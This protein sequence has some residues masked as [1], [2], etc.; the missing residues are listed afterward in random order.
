[1]SVEGT[2][3]HRTASTTYCYFITESCASNSQKCLKFVLVLPLYLLLQI[4]IPLMVEI[5]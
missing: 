1:M 3:M 5:F 2:V 4:V